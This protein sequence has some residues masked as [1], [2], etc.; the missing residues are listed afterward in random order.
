MCSENSFLLHSSK[1]ASIAAI[2]H[3]GASIRQIQAVRDR[4]GRERKRKKHSLCLIKWMSSYS[5][6]TELSGELFG[7]SCRITYS[8]Q[9]PI[10]LSNYSLSCRPNKWLW[11]NTERSRSEIPQNSLSCFSL[12]CSRLVRSFRYTAGEAKCS[13]M[14]YSKVNAGYICRIERTKTTKSPG[15]GVKHQQYH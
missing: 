7:S 4:V 2:E 10:M 3:G 13:L 5:R 1:L 6:C 8:N 9:Q 12:L 11:Q 14:A 15:W